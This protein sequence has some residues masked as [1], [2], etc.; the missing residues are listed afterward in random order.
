MLLQAPYW[1][2]GH[3]A[4]R[5]VLLN[6]EVAGALTADLSPVI[7][8]AERH[9]RGALVGARVRDIPSAWDGNGIY[10][11]IVLEESLQPVVE[12]NLQ[13]VPIDGDLKRVDCAAV[14]S[15]EAAGTGHRREWIQL[16]HLHVAVT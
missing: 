6:D 8:I 3:V 11:V 9:A 15:G 7:F 16:F 10:Y 2:H 13:L 4:E 12:H 1:P 14:K 5:L